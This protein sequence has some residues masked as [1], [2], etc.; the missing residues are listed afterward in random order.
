MSK[1]VMAAVAEGGK[2]EGMGLLDK[3]H[4]AEIHTR[5]ESHTLEVAG[6]ELVVRVV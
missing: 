4:M 1:Q 3:V 2:A 6:V 5:A